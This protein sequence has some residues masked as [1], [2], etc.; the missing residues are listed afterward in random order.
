M[1]LIPVLSAVVD[2]TTQGDG[3][4]V[5]IDPMG[6]MF[7]SAVYLFMILLPI[8]LILL[9]VFY[10]KKYQHQQVLAA[11]EKGIPVSDLIAKPV[12]RN[13]EINWIRS[14][15]AGIGFLFVALALSG[16]WLWTNKSSGVESMPPSFM[17]IPI[18]IGG[19]G[20]IY[21]F[22]GLLQRA[23]E[24]KQDKLPPAQLD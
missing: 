22:R 20:L 1:E 5:T 9:I 8:L 16:L 24:K 19:L 2:V 13:W 7:M 12:Q 23:Y 3:E 18:V 17:I 10:R 4:H 15:S 14:L 6:P 11:M 21:L